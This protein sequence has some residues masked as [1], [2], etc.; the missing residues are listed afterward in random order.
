MGIATDIY[1]Y[2]IKIF[3]KKQKTFS[4][5]LLKGLDCAIEQKIDIINLS[6]GGINFNDELIKSKLREVAKNGI[7]IIVSSGNDGQS[8]G[9]IN[10]PG[11]L[12]YVITVGKFLD[13]LFF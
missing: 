13:S 4:S 11:N 8:F 6:F 12:P 1:L 3:D 2:S 9:T 10:F 5:W 7:L